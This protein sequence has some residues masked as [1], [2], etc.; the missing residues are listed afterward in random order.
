MTQVLA[1]EVRSSS[2]GA[3]HMADFARRI[4]AEHAMK[5]HA[6]AWLEA[7]DL[8]DRPAGEKGKEK[9]PAKSPFDADFDG[10]SALEMLMEMLKQLGK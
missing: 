5:P 8:R 9:A 3:A 7:W 2:V 6:E 10:K 4:E 1:T